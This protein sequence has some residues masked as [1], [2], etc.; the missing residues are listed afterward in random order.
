M[1]KALCREH[2]SKHF[3]TFSS[4]SRIKGNDGRRLK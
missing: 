2:L 4:V 3:E 1:Y